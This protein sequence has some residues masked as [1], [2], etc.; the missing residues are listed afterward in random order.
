[1]IQA[2]YNVGGHTI[3]VHMIQNSILGCRLARPG[4]V[5]HV[6]LFLISVSSVQLPNIF[7]S[8]STN[9]VLMGVI[10]LTSACSGSGHCFHRPRNSRLEMSGKHFPLSILN[11]SC[12]L[13]C[14]QEAILILRYIYALDLVLLV[15]K[16]IS[17]NSYILL[18]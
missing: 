10:N 14:V 15:Q 13:L 17:V 9:Y 2:A 6:P 12:I 3:S 16:L 5:N 18:L 4:Q 11:L 1:M 7:I 8:F